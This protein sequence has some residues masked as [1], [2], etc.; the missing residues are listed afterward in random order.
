MGQLGCGDGGEVETAFPK[1][2][3]LEAFQGSKVSPILSESRCLPRAGHASVEL[4]HDVMSCMQA[5]WTSA[6]NDS[7]CCMCP[8]L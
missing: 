4:D 7:S 2:A 6:Y 1:L 3:T 8:E 5:S